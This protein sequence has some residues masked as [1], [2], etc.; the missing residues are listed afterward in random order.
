MDIGQTSLGSLARLRNGVRSKR[1]S[2][3]D[4]TGG[5]ADYW[6]IPAGQTLVLGEMKGSGCIRHIWMTTH[7]RDNNLRRLVLSMYWDDEV[8]PSVLC[9]L[10]DFFGLGHARAT[11]FQ[12]LPLQASYLG[13]NCWFPMPYSQAAKVC[14]TNDSDTPTILYFYIDYQEWD[15]PPEDMA[16][17]HACWCRKLVMAKDE[18]VG[19]NARG[20]EE[21][22]NISG[23]ENYVI[24]DVKGKGHYVG[25][26]LH[27]DTNRPGWWGEGDDM[28]FIDGERW[29]PSLHGTGTEDYFC[30]AWCYNF[31]SQPYSTPY[32]GYHFKGNP[33]GSG[34]HSQYRFH[35]EDPVY[36]ERS[37]R[38]SIEHGHGNDWQGDW[39]STAY[40]YQ[41]GR[42]QPLPEI[43]TFEERTPYSFGGILRQPGKD[44]KGLPW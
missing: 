27:I 26:C 11:Y 32:H 16:R 19:P 12:S 25:C 23:D 24:L 4:K 28:F 41:V 38:F 21:R 9:P 3:Y 13:L 8:T 22:L 2:S 33:D 10:G 17:F 42:K 30:G 44:R 7:E 40:W 20:K 15:Q 35:I 31:L 29:P 1:W 36:F 34:K 43:G 18:Q 39:S 37:L 5:N 6:D 14:V